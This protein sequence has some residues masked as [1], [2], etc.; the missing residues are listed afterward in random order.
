MAWSYV[1]EYGLYD[2]IRA[3]LDSEGWSEARTAQVEAAVEDLLE[4][5]ETLAVT[6]LLGY[7]AVFDELT[8]DLIANETVSGERLQEHYR[9][10]I[11]ACSR[12]LRP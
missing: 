7:R 12:K 3:N 2:G 8:A 11:D 4:R 6:L 10:L 5:A 1:A 9:P